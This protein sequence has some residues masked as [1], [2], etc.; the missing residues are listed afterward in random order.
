MNSRIST[1]PLPGSTLRTTQ[2]RAHSGHLV[3][4]PAAGVLTWGLVACSWTAVLAFGATHPLAWS[5]VQIFTFA[6]MGVLLWASAGATPSLSFPWKV[7]A[8]LVLFALLQSALLRPTPYRVDLELLN[9]FTFAAAFC[10]SASLARFPS[11][12]SCLVHGLLVLGLCQAIYGLVQ[13]I[14]GWQLIFAYKKVFYAAQATGTYINPNHFAGLLELILPFSLAF[15][16]Q[17]LDALH[18]CSPAGARSVLQSER[19]FSLIFYFFAA[20]LLFAGILLS[21]SRMGMLSMA[22]ATLLAGFLWLRRSAFTSRRLPILLLLAAAILLSLWLGLSPLL[23]RF[24]SLDADFSSRLS[25]WKDSLV[26]IRS[27]PLLG[28]GLGSF[29]DSFT[30]VQ[31]T[32]LGRTVDHAHNDYLEFAVEMGLPGALL[33][34]GLMFRLLLASIRLGLVSPRSD[35]FYLSLACAGSVV[36]LLVHS[37]ADFNLQIPANAFLFAIV[38]GLAASLRTLRPAAATPQFGGGS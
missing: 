20:L 29:A 4:P 15:S 28:T 7:P 5:V 32:H 31:T 18:A 2:V 24:S 34:F 10:L 30:R 9:W 36:A 16:L 6:L 26:L 3:P 35:S 25:V 37:L 13:S 27:H 21:R 33:L 23:A 38:L 17:R 1:L 14:A 22:L 8:A 19:L 12:R 11:S